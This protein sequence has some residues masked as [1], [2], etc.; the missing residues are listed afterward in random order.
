MVTVKV[1][2]DG[3]SFR[4]TRSM[5]LEVDWGMQCRMHHS[6]AHGKAQAVACAPH[7]EWTSPC[8]IAC[9]KSFSG[10]FFFLFLLANLSLVDG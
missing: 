3:A 6:C 2:L 1:G 5:R 9:N 8:V 4:A 10:L 7:T